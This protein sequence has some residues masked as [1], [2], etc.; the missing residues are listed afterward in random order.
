MQDG[1]RGGYFKF[2]IGSLI[3]NIF[4]FGQLDRMMC[5]S[6]LEMIGASVS[7]Y[8]SEKVCKMAVVAA[9]LNLLLA[10]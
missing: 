4:A 7:K 6:N 8:C 1:C 3:N 10:L 5:I 9:I 2:V